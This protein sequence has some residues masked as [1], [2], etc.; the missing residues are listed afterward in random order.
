MNFRSL[1]NILYLN[2]I[3]KSGIIRGRVIGLIQSTPRVHRRCRHSQQVASDDERSDDF[4]PVR[5][6]YSEAPASYK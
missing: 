5:P 6:A 4:G 2:L 1:L 3:E